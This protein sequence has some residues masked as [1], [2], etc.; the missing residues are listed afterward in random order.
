MVNDR[1]R[2]LV[3][4]GYY[5]PNLGYQ[6]NGWVKAL[7]HFGLQT[8]IVTRPDCS[9]AFRDLSNQTEYRPGIWEMDGYELQR[10][11]L[12][13]KFRS[14]VWPRGIKSVIRDFAP[15]VVI[16]F[17]VGQILPAAGARYKKEFN[18]KL[19]SVFG[20]NAMQRARNYKT[21]KFT[22]K[23]R[24]IEAAFQLFKKP[25]Y[26]RTIEISDAVGYN[27]Y[28][29]TKDILKSCLSSSKQD[30]MKKTKFLPLGYD[31]EVFFLSPQLR[32]QKRGQLGV[33]DSDYV[34]IYV[35]RVQPRRHLETLLDSF[36]PV[37]LNKNSVKLMIV[38]FLGD[39][40]ETQLK[41]YIAKL[42]LKDRVIC[43]KLT[44]R[45]ELN[46][47]YNAADIGVWHLLPTIT[48]VE[49]MGTGLPTVIPNDPS[50]SPKTLPRESVEIFE[51]SNI[52]GLKNAINNI[53]ERFDTLPD[54][55]VRAKLA[56]AR[57]YK[58]IVKR[59]FESV[60]ISLKV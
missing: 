10:M 37:M 16:A 34:F 51:L 48:L 39:S 31:G 49:A 12:Y 42:G 47:L 46:A 30:L 4:A 58:Q 56:E 29:A 22:L 20:D 52:D 59:A 15:D 23:G 9:E 24:I 25:L 17:G 38:G 54:R 19:I 53:L 6:E 44:N 26:A 50:F 35:S 60:N 32:S 7:V 36:R 5:M 11:A 55:K 27:T 3:L 28:P 8:K 14:M 33:K 43:L 40:Y 18:Y 57:E 2:V 45:N 21:G 41:E 13:A 1:I